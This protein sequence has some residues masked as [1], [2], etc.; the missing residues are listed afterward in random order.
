MFAVFLLCVLRARYDLLLDT[1]GLCII[2]VIVLNAM[3]N[4][5][6]WRVDGVWLKQKNRKKE[7]I[8]RKKS[9]TK[10]K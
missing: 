2:D 8:K 7:K 10:K 3:C 4:V 6:V 9:E 1:K 5:Q